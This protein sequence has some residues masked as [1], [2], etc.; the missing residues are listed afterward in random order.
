MKAKLA[1]APS[2]IDPTPMT[3]DGTRSLVER[4]WVLKRRDGLS[5]QVGVGGSPGGGSVTS[6]A[7]LPTTKPK[8]LVDCDGWVHEDNGFCVA[9][10]HKKP[11]KPKGGYISHDDYYGFLE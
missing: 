5:R 4:F 8:R 7:S 11:K 3:V 10:N 1:Q 2:E 6:L 9:K